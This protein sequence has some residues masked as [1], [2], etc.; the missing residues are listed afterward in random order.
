MPEVT[1]SS[2]AAV[3]IG[4]G[5]GSVLRFLLS[6]LSVQMLTSK[7]PYGTLVANTLGALLAGYA[8]VLI[9]ER[10]A[11]PHPY[12]DLLLA[13]FLGGLTTFSSMVLDAHRLFTGGQTLIALFYVCTN[14]AAGF[15]LF[16][17]AFAMSRSA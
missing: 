16:H 2:L 12:D 13:G 9:F 3:F 11:I 10:K 14:L 4:G 8:A 17:L 6:Q 7:F 5:T 1:L 15:I